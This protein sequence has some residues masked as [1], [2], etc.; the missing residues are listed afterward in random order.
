MNKQQAYDFEQTFDHQDWKPIIIKKKQIDKNKIN[1]NPKQ[2]LESQKINSIEKKAE[3]G[4][5]K[6]KQITKELRLEIQKARNSK[7]LTQKQLAQQCQ[8]TVQ[9][10]NDIESGKSIY[11][12]NHINKI[13]RSLQ[14]KHT[15]KK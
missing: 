9:I 13:K 8:L 7:G 12:H 3:I 14:I 15:N 11:N 5:L 1:I 4:D 10:I 2:S 6:H